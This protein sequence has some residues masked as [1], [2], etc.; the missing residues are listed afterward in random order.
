[1]SVVGGLLALHGLAVA[2]SVIGVSRARPGDRLMI[3]QALAIG[4]AFPVIGPVAAWWLLGRQAHKPRWA[5]DIPE[6][7]PPLPA[8]MNARAALARELAVAPLM[9]RLH[10]GQR[11]ERQAAA[12]ALAALGDARAIKVLEGALTDKDP[13]TRL[14]ASIALVRLEAAFAERIARA[15]RTENPLMLARAVRTYLA[16]GLPRGAAAR[17][18]WTEL[19]EAGHIAA[20]VA[21]PGG[22]EAWTYVA[23]ARRALGDAS[24]ARDAAERAL[25]I[26]PLPAAALELCE[27]L[28]SQGDLQALSEAALRLTKFVAPGS[29]AHQAASFWARP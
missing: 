29:P 9:D 3:C 24:G 1:V 10:A 15:R 7:P 12:R 13:D 28:W 14:F 16:S 27:I 20:D 18:L 22:A 26:A 8:L 11:D 5:N 25:A 4:L 19:G 17:E 6:P 2:A 23:A 21:M